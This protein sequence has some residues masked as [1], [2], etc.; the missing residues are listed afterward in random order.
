MDFT[1]LTYVQRDVLKEIG[2]IGAGNAATS[3]SELLD[4]KIHM[5][6][7]TVNVV[8]FDEMMDMIGGHEQLITALFFRI[9]GEMPGTVYFIL[10]LEEAQRLVG[11]ITKQSGG[12]LLGEDF[13]EIAVSALQEA[14]NILTSSYLSALS[15]FTNLHM[16]PSIPYLSID[17]A[18][19]ILTAGLVELSQVTDY[20]IIINT[21]IKHKNSEDGVQGNFFLIPDPSSFHKLYQSLGIDDHE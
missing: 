12:R 1:R 13:D 15:D 2:N 7:P 11:Q 9:E 14:G 17:M 10:S 18:G 8:G 5:Q 4:K 16:Q 20:A 21:R 19:A 6:V 3:M